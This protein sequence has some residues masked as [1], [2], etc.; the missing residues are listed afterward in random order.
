MVCAHYLPLLRSVVLRTAL[1]KFW[2]TYRATACAVRADVPHTRDGFAHCSVWEAGS[3]LDGRR[4]LRSF[5][6]YAPTRPL[7]GA[8]RVLDAS[9]ASAVPLF[10]W[11]STGAQG[12]GVTGVLTA[13]SEECPHPEHAADTSGAL[14][15]AATQ[16]LAGD[17]SEAHVVPWIAAAADARSAALSTSPAVASVRPVLVTLARAPSLASG[18]DGCLWLAGAASDGLVLPPGWAAERVLT[19]LA[20]AQGASTLS[21]ASVGARLEQLRRAESTGA[22][23]TVRW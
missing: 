18:R 2:V 8:A 19:V 12:D 3:D 15:A 7:P 23:G 14:D 11:P 4:A 20:D 13:L 16:P 10:A 9:V 6:F 1:R 21:S 17:A 22:A 5:A